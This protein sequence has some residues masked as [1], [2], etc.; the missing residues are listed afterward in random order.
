[1]RPRSVLPVTMSLSPSP[2]ISTRS[3]ACG[4]EN[5]TPYLLSA[6]SFSHDEVLAKFALAAPRDTAR[7]TRGR[8]RARRGS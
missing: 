1:M 6:G 7:T 8:S 5:F 3:I 4:S 2:S